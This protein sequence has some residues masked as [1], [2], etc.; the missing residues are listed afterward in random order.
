MY[1]LKAGKPHMSAY[2]DIQK[3]NIHY[4]LH[5]ATMPCVRRVSHKNMN[6]WEH[7]LQNCLQNINIFVW[8]TRLNTDYT[9]STSYFLQVL[10]VI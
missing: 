3:A 5:D 4:S 9:K 6:H 2:Y 1:A 7:S 10:L 8:G